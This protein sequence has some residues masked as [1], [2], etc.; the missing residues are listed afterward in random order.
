MMTTEAAAVAEP[1]GRVLFT[2]DIPAESC[3]Q[4]LETSE[5]HPL[6]AS[7]GEVLWELE[8]TGVPSEIVNGWFTTDKQKQHTSQ[9]AW[10]TRL[11]RY[12]VASVLRRRAV[13]R[14]GVALVLNR[15]EAKCAVEVSAVSGAER[16]TGRRI[17]PSSLSRRGPP[18]PSN[19]AALRR[20]ALTANESC[21]MT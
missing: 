2:L 20:A 8:L 4:M 9:L 18:V 13:Q 1:A 16:P 7:G 21:R 17:L 11:G 3:A 19:R 5:P 10:Q 14:H 6:P 15:F 12:R